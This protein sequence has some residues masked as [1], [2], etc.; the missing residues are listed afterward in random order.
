MHEN[1]PP[2]YYFY[3]APLSTAL[4]EQASIPSEKTHYSAETLAALMT[5]LKA[6]GALSAKTSFEPI[7][8]DEAHKPMHPVIPK[9]VHYA[10][11]DGDAERLGYKQLDDGDWV[12]PITTALDE[13]AQQ[14]SRVE[15]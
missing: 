10:G 12:K 15:E 6:A 8:I 2:D 4:Q 7:I 13:A 1:Q 11:Y 3:E 9:S 14:A 5:T